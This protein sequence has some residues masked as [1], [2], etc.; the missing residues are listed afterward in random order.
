MLGVVVGLIG[1]G[2]VLIDD[3]LVCTAVA[4]GVV[5]ADAEAAVEV[6]VFVK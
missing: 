5:E 1:G 6:V 4:G 3:R 2:V